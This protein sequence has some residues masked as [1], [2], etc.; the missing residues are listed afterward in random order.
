MKDETIFSSIKFFSSQVTNIFKLFLFLGDLIASSQNLER[1][2]LIVFCSLTTVKNF[3]G[4]KRMSYGLGY[5]AKIQKQHRQFEHYHRKLRNVC[6]T[7]HH[8]NFFCLAVFTKR[9]FFSPH[10]EENVT[11]LVMLVCHWQFV[12]PSYLHRIFQG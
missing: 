5:F 1:T 9:I 4:L 10:F 3:Q 2:N 6:L 12:N 11:Q 8:Q 7:V